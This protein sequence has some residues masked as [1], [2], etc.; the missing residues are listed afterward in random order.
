LVTLYKNVAVFDIDDVDLDEF[1]EDSPQK[2]GKGGKGADEDD[3]ADFI[4][5]SG[6][7]KSQPAKKKVPH[8]PPPFNGKT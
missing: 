5:A 1:L 7:S 6:F 3:T 8:P 4:A 2:K